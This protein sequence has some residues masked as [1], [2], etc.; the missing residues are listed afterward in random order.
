[1]KKITNLL[2][3]LA[4]ALLT[5]CDNEIE[6]VPS[7]QATPYNLEGTWRLDEWNADTLAEN[8]Y[9]YLVLDSKLTFEMYQ[10]TNSMYTQLITGTYK[11]EEDW[12]V[13]DVISGTYDYENGAWN[14]EYIVTS[15]YKESM[16]WTAKDDSTDVQKFVRV[17]AVPAHIVD[18]ARKP[19]E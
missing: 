12:R 17:D 1:M 19:L 5:A 2:M 14:H 15:L 3:L 10:N 4:V 11:I 7:L 18:E 9:V 8:T 13:G 6:P 16:T